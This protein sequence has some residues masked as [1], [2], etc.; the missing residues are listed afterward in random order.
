MPTPRRAV[1]AATA[2]LLA[3]ACVVGGAIPATAAPP[4]AA[5]P[6][7]EPQ[8][9][10]G[11]A[12]DTCTAPALDVLRAWRHRSPYGALGIYILSLIHI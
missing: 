6:S 4:L 12:F 3:L 9:F 1:A 2:L 8:V 7:D 10:T 11:Q 5:A